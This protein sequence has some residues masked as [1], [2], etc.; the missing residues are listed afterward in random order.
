[1]THVV[2]RC[3]ASPE[4]GI[5]HLV[6][7]ISVADAARNAGHSAVLAGAI[8]SVLAT[9]LVLQSALDIVD[10]PDDL[11]ILA[12]EQ[13]ASVIHVDNYDIGADAA[14]HVHAAGALLSSMEDGVFGRRRAD[15]VVDS[16][17]R[18]EIV[19]RP[20]D[21]SGEVLLGIGY[22]PMRAQVRAAREKRAAAARPPRAHADVLIVMGGTD[23]TGA[24]ATVAAV[25]RGAAGV[26]RVT[27]V[28]PARHWDAVRAEAGGDVEL[29]APAP[30]FLD[31]AAAADLVVSAAGTTSWELVCIG[32]PS[33]LVAVVE[34]Q[35]AGYEA[36]IAEG[37][38][39]GLGTLDE[40]RADPGSAV[41]RVEA[42]VAALRAGGSWSTSG[43][44]KVDGRGAE[45]I[46][47][48]WEGA[49]ARRFDVGGA[50]VVARA[51]TTADSLLLLR[52]RNDPVTRAMSRSSSP[53][54]FPAHT[55]WFQRVLDDA[56]RELYVVERG[57]M[58]V[59]TVRFDKHGQSDWEVSIALAPEARGRG[60]SRSVL[61]AGEAMFAD[62]HS[63]ASI[64]AAVLP[65]N[66]PSQR[67][68][69]GAG[70]TVDPD[71]R[72]GDF[73]VL[74]RDR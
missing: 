37:V 65:D 18:A 73:D 3:D 40:V 34:N 1:M 2:I 32:V 53:I 43:V 17:I 24:A 55:A 56:L 13:G 62:S 67:L 7:A 66:E 15:V 11:G 61:A 16:T 50:A 19:G 5:G 31:R 70:Y 44:V 28:V 12:A 69:R 10:A 59:G 47:A 29:V 4:G 48:A 71:R 58:P 38:A 6:R 20:D 54:A 57:G 25:C 63:R 33:L 36:A 22:A 64:I 8:S 46:V 9:D 39:L 45:R 52:W 27:V 60:L 41:A 49:V 23:A 14:V 51:A 21:G 72:D 74:V 42:A 68:F 30:D 35:R 26:R